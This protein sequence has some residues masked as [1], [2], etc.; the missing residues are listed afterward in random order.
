LASQSQANLARGDLL[1]E[2]HE[3][4][5]GPLH[6]RL[7]RS[8]LVA[9]RSGR[10]A[11]GTRLPPS[12]RLATDLGC[13]RWVVTETYAQL[14]AEGYLE[15]RTGSAT[16]V[17]RSDRSGAMRSDAS[18]PARCQ[19]R[20][21]L[22]PGI[23]DLRAFPR[24]RWAAA[25]RAAAIRM[26]LTDLGY[27]LP[28]GHR[29]LRQ[30]L[31]GYLGRVRG[32][33]AGA[34][35]ITICTGITDGI[36]QVC[37][38]LAAAGVTAVALE[39]PVWPRLRRT[40]ANAGL[41]T[42]PVPVDEQGLVVDELAAHPDVGAVIVAP[43]HQFPTGALLAPARR[44]ALLE[45]ARRTDGLVLEDDYDAEF[46]YDRMPV[47]TMQGMDSRRVLLFGSASK[48]LSP[49][50][51]IGWIVAPPRWTRAVQ[52]ANVSN[53][54]PPM[55]DQ[56]A[57]ATFVESGSL[58]RHRRTS[59]QRYR[60]RRDALIQAIRSRLPACRVSGIAAG[61]HLLL[62]LP[63]GADG[64]AVAAEAAARGVPVWNLDTCRSLATPANP[65]LVI[66]YGNLADGAAGDAVGLLAA[67]VEAAGA[68]G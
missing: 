63:A 28:G 18:A 23:P 57:F 51:G 2:M 43:A 66:G 25:I 37:R 14:V 65:A 11:P 41:A 58:D 3:D 26:G 20:F 17:S 27:P 34:D 16:R 53:A 30:A 32:T 60:A 52:A 62:H 6:L 31:A 8:L 67:A 64:E 61:L 4:G 36:G 9:I 48:T 24:Q 15:A 19:P 55:L 47:A 56:F 45:W 7:R 54:G 5:A 40:A 46:R 39:D 1:V 22:A 38:A 44:A 29:R 68:I 50:L 49:A 13:S 59:R 12:R 10:L 35:D 21:D 33:V 42:V